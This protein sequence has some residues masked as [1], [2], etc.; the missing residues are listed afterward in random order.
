M[1]QGRI[2]L[3]Y[4]IYVGCIVDP[5]AFSLRI[6]HTSQMGEP[7]NTLGRHFLLFLSVRI[8][9]YECSYGFLLYFLTNFLFMSK[10][11][12]SVINLSVMPNIKF[13]P[14]TFDTQFKG[15]FVI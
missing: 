6:L 11:I 1:R 13:S 3:R 14:R 12:L 5:A 15:V 2:E 10:F 9:C 4:G 7:F 8:K